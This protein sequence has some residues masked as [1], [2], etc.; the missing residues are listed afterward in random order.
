MPQLED[1]KREML[2]MFDSG[3]RQ[4]QSSLEI[5]AGHLHRRVFVRGPE[6]MSVCC[7]A[8]RQQYDPGAGDSILCGEPNETSAEF[9]I[10]YRLP[11]PGITVNVLHV[12]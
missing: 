2:S 8:M 12:D 3:L 6:V 7:A 10:D 5:S 4:N 1:C 9:T 11:R